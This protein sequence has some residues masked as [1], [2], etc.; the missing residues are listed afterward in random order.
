MPGADASSMRRWSGWPTLSRAES[1][2]VELDLSAHPA[3]RGSRTTA[4][5][6]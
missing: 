5:C 3:P 4:V 6:E 2:V 1:N